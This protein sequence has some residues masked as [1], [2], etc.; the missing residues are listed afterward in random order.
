MRIYHYI[1]V[2]GEIAIRYLHINLLYSSNKIEKIKRE[3]K[4]FAFLLAIE[5]YTCYI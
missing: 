3:I 5:R 2:R 1:I 4:T